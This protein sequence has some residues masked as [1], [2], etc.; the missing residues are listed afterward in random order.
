MMIKNKLLFKFENWINNLTYEEKERLN[1][2]L[3]LLVMFVLI[4][5]FITI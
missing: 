1:T 3:Y 5:I 2:A 4:I